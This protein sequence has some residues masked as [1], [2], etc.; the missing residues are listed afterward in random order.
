MFAGL[1]IN[2]DTFIHFL[3]GHLG[4]VCSV[5]PRPRRGQPATAGPPRW[6]VT[7]RFCLDLEQS[8]GTSHC[9]TSLVLEPHMESRSENIS[10]AA[11]LFLVQGKTSLKIG[12]SRV[13][14]CILK[15][16]VQTQLRQDL[17]QH[18][19][20]YL[21]FNRLLRHAYDL[22]MISRVCCDG[23]VVTYPLS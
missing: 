1:L 12:P 14:I 4:R 8:P 20:C 16:L 6:T 13:P 11:R 10:R 18:A 19:L 17:N 3:T 15:R 22:G 7:V 9:L 5:P 21:C 2:R 23:S